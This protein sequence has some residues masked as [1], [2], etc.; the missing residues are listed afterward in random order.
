MA[1][2]RDGP[3]WKKIRAEYIKGGISQ[4]KLAAKHGVSYA[5]LRRRAEREKWRD[6]KAER[7]QKV[8]EKLPEKIADIQTDTAARLMQMQSEAALAIYGKL[9]GTLK[10]FPDGV[11]TKNVRETVEVKK[12]KVNGQEREFPLHKTFTND[13]EAVVRSMTSLAR[14][15]GIDAA[16]TLSRERFELQKQQGGAVDD[17][18]ALNANVVSIAE[19]INH[20][21][22]DRTMEQVEG[23]PEGSGGE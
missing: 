14:L 10:S 8:A 12:I 17:T 11:G 16:A 20:P 6:L 21:M 22:P 4:E 3:N 7:E 15:Y 5:T 19:L 13:L 1:Q 9:L 18:D 2:T 23:K